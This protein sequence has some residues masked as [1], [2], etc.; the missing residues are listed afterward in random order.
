MFVM[1]VSSMSGKHTKH[2]SL[3]D[4][5]IKTVEKA[6]MFNSLA[7][8][9]ACGLFESGKAVRYTVAASRPLIVSYFGVCTC[10]ALTL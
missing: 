9:R 8:D 5:R 4:L 6:I 2:A 1:L 10:E 7:S 3:Q